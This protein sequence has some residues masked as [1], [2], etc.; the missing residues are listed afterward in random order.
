M[1]QMVCSSHS[2]LSLTQAGDGL[3][4]KQSFIAFYES[5]LMH[6]DT[7]FCLSHFIPN[8]KGNIY[9]SPLH[10]FGHGAH[11]TGTFSEQ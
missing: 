6:T 2:I 11:P 5:S 7:P 10:D 4:T 9:P 1:R 8:Q 3:P